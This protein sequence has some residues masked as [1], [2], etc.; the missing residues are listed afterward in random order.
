MAASSKKNQD[1]EGRK[2]DFEIQRLSQEKDK[3]RRTTR[4]QIARILSIFVPL[5]IAG[6]TFYQNVQ[7]QKEQAE[8]NFELKAAE[9]VLNESN[10]MATFNKA[11]AL[12]A[13]FPRRFSAEFASS[14]NPDNY[15]GPDSDNIITLLKMIAEHP[16]QK[17]AILKNWKSVLPG[18]NWADSIK[19]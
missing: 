7:S 16:D 17:K 8:L 4:V 9:I 18:D 6:I 2:L 3:A 15:G 19:F 10:P 13:L 12:A 5:V 1:I 14:F 11:K